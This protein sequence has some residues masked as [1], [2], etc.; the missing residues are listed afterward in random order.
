MSPYETSSM[1]HF[2]A[3]RIWAGKFRVGVEDHVL[4]EEFLVRIK[5]SAEVTSGVW[6]LKKKI[7][8]FN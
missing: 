2:S 3:F 4:A 5:F 1:I 8:S 7:K 6:I